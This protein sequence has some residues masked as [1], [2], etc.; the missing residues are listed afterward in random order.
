MDGERIYRMIGIMQGRLSPMI[1]GQ[2]QAFPV[3]AWKDEFR[4][5]NDIG[6]T[7]IEWTLD[8]FNLFDNF[9]TFHQNPCN[10]QYLYGLFWWVALRLFFDN[11]L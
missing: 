9:F 7:H 1:D 5:A 8:H 3:E 6:F 10:L 11:N 2:I 4:L